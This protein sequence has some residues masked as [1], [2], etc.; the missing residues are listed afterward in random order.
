MRTTES[1]RT[2]VYLDHVE[3][4]FTND[5]GV[6]SRRSVEFH[7][8]QYLNGTILLSAWDFDK[9]AQR[10][11]DVTKLSNVTAQRGPRS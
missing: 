6:R 2:L 1:P 10:S 7:S 11:F 8:F 4:D 9:K 3:F 5:A